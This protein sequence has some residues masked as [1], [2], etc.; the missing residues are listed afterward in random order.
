MTGEVMSTETIHQAQTGY[1]Y[2]ATV[3]I[4]VMDC[5]TC[6][7]PFGVPAAM[8]DRL[9]ESHKNFYCPSGH[10]MS[11]KGKT[12][13]ERLKEQRDRARQAAA[14][15][16]ERAE[17]LSQK[18]RTLDYQARYAKGRLTLM[19]NRLQRGQ[20]PVDRCKAEFADLHEHLHGVH[21][22]FELPD[23]L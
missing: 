9:R 17:R 12:E 3:D 14:R 6:H 2:G 8:I 23:T 10:S 13:I 1:Q 16:D 22:E 7:V 19:R 11:F 21:P 18:A 4:E 5:P 15:S 20:C